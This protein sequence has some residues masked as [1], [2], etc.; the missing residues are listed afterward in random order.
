MTERARDAF[1]TQAVIGSPQTC[2]RQ[3]ESFLRDCEIDGL[4]FIF[5]DYTAGIAATGSEILPQ[6]RQ[7]FA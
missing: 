1:I 5:D 4:M 7:A 2:A 3:I 6:L